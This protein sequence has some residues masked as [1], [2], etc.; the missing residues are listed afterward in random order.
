MFLSMLLGKKVVVIPNSSKFYDFQHRPVMSD[1][2]TALD[3]F[4]KAETFSGLL[5]EC[6]TINMDFSMKAF[7]YL[8]L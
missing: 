5:E 8:N 1:F 2:N 7:D 6:R 3:Q 4:D